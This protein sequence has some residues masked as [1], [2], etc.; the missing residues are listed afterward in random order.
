MRTL[1]LTTL[2]LGLCVITNAQAHYKLVWSDDFSYTGLPDS[3]KWSYDTGGNGWG[4]NELQCYTSR[5]NNS[6][7]ENGHL[8]IEARQENFERRKFTSARLLTR[9]KAAW[10]YGRFEARIKIPRG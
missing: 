3:S 10:T 4:N 2:L 9:G 1:A 7:I 5:T 8:V 6:R